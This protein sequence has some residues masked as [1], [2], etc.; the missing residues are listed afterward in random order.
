VYSPV[1]EEVARKRV[2]GKRIG[3]F[4]LSHDGNDGG[5]SIEKKRDRRGKQGDLAGSTLPKGLVT[6]SEKGGAL[7]FVQGKQARMASNK[8]AE[9]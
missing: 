1:G 7:H 4:P 6:S 5:K 9:W 2:K 8:H 3:G